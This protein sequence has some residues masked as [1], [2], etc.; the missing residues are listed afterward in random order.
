M[1]EAIAPYHDRDEWLEMRKSGIG[2]SDAAAILGVHPFKS[3]LDVYED[4]IGKAAP[5]T[6][7]KPMQRGIVLEPIAADLYQQETGRGI[8]RQPLKRHPEYDFMIGNV[9]RQ[10]FAGSGD[11]EYHVETTGIL[12]IKCPGLRT[13]SRVAAHGLDDYMTVQLMHYLA[14]TGYEW[15][16]FA[17]FNAERW[18]VVHFDL[19]RDDE[20]IE[21][22]IEREMRF[23]RDHVEA[24]VPPE[25]ADPDD[26]GVP[27]VDGELVIKDEPKWIEIA[28]D[29]REGRQL[30]D[31]AKEL[32]DNAKARLQELMKREEVQAVEVPDVGRF[33]YKQMDGRTSWKK[34]AQKLAQ[35]FDADVEKYI[36]TGSSYERFSPFFFKG[37]SE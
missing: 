9:D 17:L 19:E 27:E 4:K 30:K 15:G 26:A 35:E 25:E 29:F 24:R 31:T 16:S 23:W 3:A 32:E 10:V 2:G 20:F 7:T 34:T 14:V 37:G 22:L 12:E 11:G 18:D 6:I 36:V 13:M 1:T 33:Y 8:R 5:V 28:Q 21:T